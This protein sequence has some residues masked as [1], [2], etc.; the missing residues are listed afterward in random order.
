MV[1][2]VEMFIIYDSVSWIISGS[3][4]SAGINDKVWEMTI[5]TT[6]HGKALNN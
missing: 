1:H 5:A 6:H 3:K 2:K 4:L